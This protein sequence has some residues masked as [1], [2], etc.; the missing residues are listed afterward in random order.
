MAERKDTRVIVGVGVILTIDGSA[1]PCMTRNLSRGGMF[2]VTRRKAPRGSMVGLEVVRDG[3][4]LKAKAA[5]V[6]CADD[7]LGLSFVGADDKFCNAIRALMDEM[8]AEKMVAPSEEESVADDAIE[9][10]A[11]WGPIGESK[12]WQVF[13]KKRHAATFT[14]LTLDGASLQSNASPPVGQV[15]LFFLMSSAL[16]GGVV[17]ST[18]EVVRHTDTGFAVRF[19]AASIEFRRAISNAR[20]SKFAR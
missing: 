18:A 12:W 4:R 8:V 15:I 6:E 3:Q 10:G 5:V 9:V 1:E 17:Q 7:G 13:Q 14:N 16:E 11:A 20:R 2:A 19:L